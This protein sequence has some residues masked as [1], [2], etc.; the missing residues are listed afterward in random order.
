MYT[1]MAYLA[2]NSKQACLLGLRLW[3]GDAEGEKHG[4]GNMG[5]D[6]KVANM[7]NMLRRNWA[8]L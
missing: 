1:H 7:H 3:D 5:W 8:K 2:S 4:K 6:E